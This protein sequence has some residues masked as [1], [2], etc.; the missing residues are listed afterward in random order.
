MTEENHRV[1]GGI[2]G[3]FRNQNI[4]P[5]VGD[6]V[7]V[8]K[9]KDGSFVIAQI[10]ERKNALLR[11]AVANVTQMIIV[12]ACTRPKPNL[13]M[14]DKLIASYE[15]IGLKIIMCF[16][17][18]DIAKKADVEHLKQIYGKTSYE[19]F[20][21]SA[22]EAKLGGLKKHLYHETTVL[23]GPSGAGKSTLLNAIHPAFF[24][25]YRKSQ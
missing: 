9:E 15:Q 24:F 19:L 16:N 2:K 11:P 13:M 7:I 12:A 6:N 22:K 20:F 21:V 4:V 23:A 18:V 17:K 1:T 10:L 5:M 8:Q 25:A 14:L 3:I